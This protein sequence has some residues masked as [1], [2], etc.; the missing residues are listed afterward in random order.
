MDRDSG[1][2]GVADRDGGSVSLIRAGGSRRDTRPLRRS[3]R[4]RWAGTGSWGELISVQCSEISVH[5]G[6]VVTSRTTSNG[7]KDVITF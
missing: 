6:Q 4:P 5:S 3:S 2:S 1:I 7:V